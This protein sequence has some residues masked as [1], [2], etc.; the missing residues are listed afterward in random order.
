M[1]IIF[2]SGFIARHFFDY[3]ESKGEDFSVITAHPRN[4]L[5]SKYTR[6]KAIY[7]PLDISE[8]ELSEAIGDTG[9]V[10][11]LTGSAKPSSFSSQ[12]WMILRE[13]V[14][15]TFQRLSLV[16]AVAQRSVNIVY[17]SSAGA[18]YG[19]TTGK[20]TE[21]SLTNPISAYGL[22]KLLIEACVAF[23]SRTT[24]HRFR[25]LRI[26]NPVGRH[27][28]A[29]NHG[30]VSVA[31]RKVLRMEEIQIFGS[32]DVERDYVDADDVA[33]AI[34]KA[35]ASPDA[36]SGIWNVGK[37]Q[38]S[39]I[40]DVL[41]AIEAVTGITPQVQIKKHRGFDVQKVDL[42]VDR[43]CADFEWRPK[44]DLHDIV[45]KVYREATP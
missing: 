1:H 42:S 14:E 9:A 15:V 3:L 44:Y 45:R 8:A 12:P 24:P 4:D 31:I 40:R 38:S 2:G 23:L 34:W 6:L 18:I 30:L 19:E 37:G 36:P 32:L 21:S 11:Y 33:D 22:G 5:K 27:Q 16:A 28:V 26:S 10:Y 7:S 13:E 41:D 17:A 20:L 39:S 29:A 35:S 43:F 25:V